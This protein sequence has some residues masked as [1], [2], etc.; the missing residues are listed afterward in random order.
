V[1]AKVET[2]LSRPFPLEIK[3]RILG[4]TVRFCSIAGEDI[5]AE[6]KYMLT[7]LKEYSSRKSCHMG[8]ERQ[9]CAVYITQMR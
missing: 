1:Q 5:G 9:C 3:V 8:E 7:A 2:R 4:D 6:L